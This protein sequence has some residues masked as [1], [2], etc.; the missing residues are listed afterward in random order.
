MIH[1]RWSLL[2]IMCDHF[3]SKISSR[4]SDSV[5][6]TTC[7]LTFWFQHHA[8]W[9]NAWSIIY[10]NPPT[11]SSPST[12]PIVAGMASCSLITASTSNAVLQR[13]EIWLNRDSVEDYLYKKLRNWSITAESVLKLSA[14]SDES[15][16]TFSE[17][18]AIHTVF[19]GGGSLMPLWTFL[20]QRNKTTS[21]FIQYNT[22]YNK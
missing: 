8:S 22:N 7:A 18:S 17:V 4:T 10:H 1:V 21:L 13:K 14:S 19:C 5:T 3:N 11:V 9:L 6:P 16:S 2:K 15:F 20:S 12:I